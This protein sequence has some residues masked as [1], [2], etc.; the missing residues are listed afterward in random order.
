[1]NRYY[2]IILMDDYYK[3]EGLYTKHWSLDNLLKI[4]IM[5]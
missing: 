2:Y 1:M 5:L 4:F 3:E